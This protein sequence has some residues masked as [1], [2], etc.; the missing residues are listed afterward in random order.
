MSKG[1]WFCH[2]C[3]HTGGLEMEKQEDFRPRA[4]KIFT[5]PKY[6]ESALPQEVLGWFQKRGIPEGVLTANKIGWGRSFTDFPYFKGGEVVNIKYQFDIIH[7]GI[8][9]RGAPMCAPFSK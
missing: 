3:G 2:H 5:R 4:R 9:R 8:E 6:Q 7:R 1:T